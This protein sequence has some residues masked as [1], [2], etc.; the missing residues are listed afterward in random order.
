[1]SFPYSACYQPFDTTTF[2]Q[3]MTNFNKIS[4]VLAAFLFATLFGAAAI[5]ADTFS[6]SPDTLTFT[7]TSQDSVIEYVRIAYNGD[8]T[9]PGTYIHARVYDGSSYFN[10][11]TDTVFTRSYFYLRVAYKPQSSTVYGELLISDDSITRYVTL[12]GNA[13][14]PEDGLLSGYGPY[15]PTNTPEGKDTCTTMRLI[16]T[17]RDLDTIVS[18][19]WAHDPGGIFT[20]DSVSVP[21][22]SLHPAIRRSGRSAS[23]RRIIPILISTRS[24]FIITTRKARHA[25]SRVSSKDRPSVR[26]MPRFSSKVRTSQPTFRKD[27]IPAPRCGSSMQEPTSIPSRA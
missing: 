8:T 25:S 10:C 16:N 26:R 19:G 17:G 1:M 6:Y 20:W 5:Y 23:M 4:R 12:I 21:P 14:T 11:P 13:Y 18:A 27:T 7:P 24:S 22:Q 15:F 9:G 3:N 2:Q